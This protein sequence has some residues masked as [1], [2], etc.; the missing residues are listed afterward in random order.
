M[1]ISGAVV[2]KSLLE[3][4]EWSLHSA[5][6]NFNVSLFTKHSFPGRRKKNDY[7]YKYSI[8][9]ATDFCLLSI[10]H[11]V[12]PGSTPRACLSRVYLTGAGN[13]HNRGHCWSIISQQ[14]FGPLLQE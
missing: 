13:L 11:A 7:L 2:L 5:S 4:R 10:R 9:H 8:C 12:A 1:K 3:I 6:Q 14:V